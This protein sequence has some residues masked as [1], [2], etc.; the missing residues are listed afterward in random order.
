MVGGKGEERRQQAKDKYK[1]G[2]QEQRNIRRE[3]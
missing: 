1:Q 3:M 2:I